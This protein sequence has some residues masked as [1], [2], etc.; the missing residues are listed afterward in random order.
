MGYQKLLFTTASGL[1]IA[2][3]T[4]FAYNIFSKKIENAEGDIDKITTIIINI[5]TGKK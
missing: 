2:I 4:V 5:F 1:F 3:P